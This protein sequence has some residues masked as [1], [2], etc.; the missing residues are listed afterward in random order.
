MHKLLIDINVILDVAEARPRHFESSQRLLTLIET[1]KVKGFMSAL[2]H[3][4]IYY[5]LTKEIGLRESLDFI[6]KL[7][8][9]MDVVAV[10]F[11]V[12]E[13]AIKIISDDFEDA[14]QAVCAK[15]CGADYIVTRDEE[16]Y[17]G[18]P[19]PAI[20]PAEYLATFITT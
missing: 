17:K 2:S 7:L 8:Q 3:P 1:G 13:S 12:L 10:D 6:N 19:V 11:N 9:L 18:S 16:G 5:L 14:I 20:T 4:I 15:K